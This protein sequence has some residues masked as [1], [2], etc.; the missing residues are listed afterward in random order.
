MRRTLCLLVMV[1]AAVAPAFAQTTD[2]RAVMHFFFGSGTPLVSCTPVRACQLVLE[3]GETVLDTIAG[4]SSHWQIVRGTTGAGAP[5]YFI[6][7]SDVG[8][9]TSNLIISTTRRI[10][11]VHLEAVPDSPHEL[12]VFDY[13]HSVASLA[14]AVA[15]NVA[16]LSGPASYD[17][18][19]R[20]SGPSWLAPTVVCTDGAHTWLQM[21]ASLPDVPLLYTIDANGQ[22]ELV[23]VHRDLR[24]WR[25]DGVPRKIIIVSGAQRDA[26]QV[27][28]EY[29]TR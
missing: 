6:K 8:V 24:W 5:T 18:S 23:T 19:Y 21:P 22:Q 28:V 1:A 13:P 3:P 4:D 12:Y 14:P 25:I 16:V 29:L 10:Y 27:S 11:D 26:A 7:P 2:P 15:S 17:F 20:T 9:P